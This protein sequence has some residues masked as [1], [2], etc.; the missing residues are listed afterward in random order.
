MVGQGKAPQRHTLLGVVQL[1]RA[2]ATMVVLEVGGFKYTA[3]FGGSAPPRITLPEQAW[4]GATLSATGA[5]WLTVSITP[6]ATIIAT[7]A[8][9]L[10]NQ[11]IWLVHLDLNRGVQVFMPSPWTAYVVIYLS[12]SL[13]LLILSALRVRRAEA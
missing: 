12:L 11:G 2:D 13:I 9:L 7:E 8:A 10:D 1:Q 6:G 4:K 3:F 5:D